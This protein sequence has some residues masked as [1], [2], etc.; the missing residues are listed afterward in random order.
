MKKL[1]M[2]FS[3]FCLAT[4]FTNAKRLY[5]EMEYIKNTIRLNDGSN[6]KLQTIKGADGE[7]LKFKSLIGAL[8]Y[9]SLQGWELL[10]TK[11]INGG[12]A[13]HTVV[14]YYIFYKDVPDEELEAVVK[15]S[16]KQD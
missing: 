5:V 4:Q 14:A 6:K 8:N 1:I 2:L 12:D 10:D 16:F 7:D 15:K 11:P 13:S 3:V 9:M